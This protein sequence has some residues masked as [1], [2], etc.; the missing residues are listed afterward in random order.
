MQNNLKSRI[1][2]FFAIICCIFLI[3]PVLLHSQSI[4]NEYKVSE[5]QKQLDIIHYNF[6][7]QLLANEKKID[8]ESEITA[9]PLN[10]TLKEI[11]LNL[12]DNMDITDIL[13]NGSKA[14]YFRDK[15]RIFI[16]SD[17]ELTDTVKIW[18]K[19]HGHPKRA[20]FDGFVFGGVNGSTL[21][22]NISEP[23]FAPTWFV[24][25]DDPADKALLDMEITNDSQFVS[26]SNGI[27]E[28]IK[29]NN[30]KKTYCYKTIYPI[31]TYLIAVY[32]APFINYHDLYTG[33]SGR[34][35]M[36]IEYF[37]LPEHL[38]KSKI[39]FANHSDMIRVLSELFGEYPFIKEKYGVAE[40]LWNFGAMENQTITGIGYN[41][42]GGND[43]FKDTYVHELS[44]HWWGDSVTP[45]SWDDIWLNEGFASYCEALYAEAKHGEPAL[46]SKMMSKFSEHFRGT[47]YAPRDLFSE[48][49][50]DKGAWVLHMLRFEVGDSIFFKT[51]RNYYSLYKYSNA[52]V[53]DFKNVC[54]KTFG[55]S[56]DKFFDQWVYTGDEIP[57]CD[58]SYSFENRDGKM[59]CN[60]A[61]HQKQNKY[62]EFHF[63][64]EIRL[65]YND[66]KFETKK[67]QIESRDQDFNFEISDELMEVA[68]DPNSN[69]LAIFK[70]G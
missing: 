18:I 7:I 43:F 5:I 59:Y 38:E 39:D 21:I 66:E 3:N 30:G 33:L 44:H 51:M 17:K 2:F 50:Y 19:Y 45:K 40:F 35:S 16:K 48:T 55:K 70:L 1:S 63:P 42:V 9:V 54:E 32:S 46:I 28:S 27:L 11:E 65:K 37:V 69:L 57:I 12:Y 58:Y 64:L 22:Y 56:L 24:C 62:G 41:F 60:F 68:V 53:E 36:K 14:N 4:R 61:I 26:A 34:D 47:L 10:P 25:D 29:N 13:F 20:G 52:S 6:K 31:A 49:I 8:C 67:L 15:N 23:T